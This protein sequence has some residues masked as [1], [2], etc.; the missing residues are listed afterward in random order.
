MRLA[1]FLAKY[2]LMRGY[3][4]PR[5][6]AIFKAYTGPKREAAV[7]AQYMLQG[8]IVLVTSSPLYFMF[9]NV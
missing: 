2:R 7:F 6:E 5:Y 3:H 9:K 1:G 8:M 4:D